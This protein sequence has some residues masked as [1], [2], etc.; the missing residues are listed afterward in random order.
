MVAEAVRAPELG[1]I[2]YEQGPARVH[3]ELSRYLDRAARRG[4]LRCPV[5]EL[6][7]KLFLGAIVANHQI[8]G[9]IAPD[10]EPF[11]GKK[12]CAHIEEAVELFL[13]RYG[14]SS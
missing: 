5:P 11:N 6:A 12:M 14:P 13:A 10:F 1:R 7:A 8:L 9:L 3:R 4:E 2:F